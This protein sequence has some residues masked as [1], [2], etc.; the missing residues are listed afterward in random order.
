MVNGRAGA[1][2]AMVSLAVVTLA[3]A[4]GCAAAGAAGGAA[5]KSGPSRAAR[6][7]CSADA[8]K[9][10]AGAVGATTDGPIAPA[11]ADHL[12]SCTY[13]YAD[14]RIGLS[15]KE[16]TDAA[17]TTAY[18]TAMDARLGQGGDVAGIG[19]DAYQGADGSVVVRK[20]FKVLHVDVSGLPSQFGSP[21]IDRGEAALRIAVTVMGC[22]K[23]D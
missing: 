4:T 15:V 11:W 3:V 19:Q 18:F 9:E 5:P 21:P 10:I 12:Y 16:L 23:D 17:T 1:V 14:G 6:M 7:V 13:P 2:L 20:D 8:Q 22:W